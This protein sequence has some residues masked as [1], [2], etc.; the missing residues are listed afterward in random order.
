MVGSGGPEGDGVCVWRKI[1]IGKTSTD[2]QQKIWHISFSFAENYKRLNS[3][4]DFYI[5]F[6]V[7]C[8]CICRIQQRVCRKQHT[9]EY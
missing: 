8:R 4:A 7:F 2:L 5:P 9:K 6:V 3:I 1:N